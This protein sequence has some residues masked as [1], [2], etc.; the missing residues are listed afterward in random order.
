MRQLRTHRE[1]ERR[2]TAKLPCG[3]SITQM[4]HA[5]PKS[6]HT[7]M[8]QSSEEQGNK[9]VEGP[10]FHCPWYILTSTLMESQ[11][12]SVLFYTNRL[13]SF[14]VK[15]NSVLLQNSQKQHCYTVLV[16]SLGDINGW[17]FVALGTRVESLK[18]NA[19][20]GMLAQNE[21][22]H[23]CKNSALNCSTISRML[24]YSSWLEY[25]VSQNSCS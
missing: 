10:T 17:W 22:T 4:P 6:T 19:E 5:G 16:W 14:T 15:Q 7:L 11:V 2:S 8:P 21:P 25:H 23:C 9:T 13:W 18:W 3:S 1:R 24:A 12:K 20:M